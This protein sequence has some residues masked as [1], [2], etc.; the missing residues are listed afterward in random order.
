MKVTETARTFFTRDLAVTIPAAQVEARIA[1][2]IEDLGRVYTRHGFRPGKVP[3]D[4]IRRHLGEAVRTRM[5]DRLVDAAVA[6]AT[7]AMCLVAEPETEV[8]SI[9]G[10][11]ELTVRA[12]HR[13][14]LPCPCGIRGLPFT[15]SLHAYYS[16][17]PPLDTDAVSGFCERTIQELDTYNRAKAAA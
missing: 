15:A 14:E 1:E 4:V 17:L 5:I 9:T 12:R 11:V 7:D 6:H 10:D 3:H 8:L 13:P 16:A 2:E